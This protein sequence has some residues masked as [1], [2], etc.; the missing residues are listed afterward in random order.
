MRNHDSPSHCIDIDTNNTQVSVPSALSMSSQH[1]ADITPEHTTEVFN[2]FMRNVYATLPVIHVENFQ[3]RLKQDH[4]C[5]DVDF[6][7]LCHALDLLHESYVVALTPSRGTGKVASRMSIMQQL[8]CTYDYAEEATA[9]TA[10]AS[11]SF[12]VA[13]C[14]LG[15]HQRAM[16]SLSE[17]SKLTGFARTGSRI[18]A[19]RI[20]RLR[21]LLFVTASA[22]AFLAGDSSPKMGIPIPSVE[23]MESW[24]DR[25]AADTVRDLDH[26]ATCQLQ[27][28]AR[29]HM[30]ARGGSRELAEDDVASITACSAALPATP[31]VRIVTADLNITQLWISSDRRLKGSDCDDVTKIS[32]SI[33]SV[34]RNGRKALAWARS[35]SQSELRIIGLGKMVDILDR[36]VHL[37]DRYPEGT[38]EA[39]ILA[40]DL[41][42]EIS[43]ADYESTYA[44]TLARCAAVLGCTAG[45]S[46][47][48]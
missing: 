13:C 41:M 5:W 29:M 42:D 37:C 12:F 18:E 3:S 33:D 31:T 27:Q 35:L 44:T 34:E 39:E 38:A 17:A 9:D 22:S 25:S 1:S 20:Q 48:V 16:L 10:I 24:Y 11:F 45:L 2:F 28:M 43:K 26:F 32:E 19:M 15:K 30:G 46:V 4:G 14:V 36:M 6:L 23:D 40:R 47:R 7:L 21:A 8:R